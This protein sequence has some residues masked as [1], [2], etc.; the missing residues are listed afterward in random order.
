M[1]VVSCLQI[2]VKEFNF[3]QGGSLSIDKIREFDKKLMDREGKMKRKKTIPVK[4]RRKGE[5][6]ENVLKCGKRSQKIGKENKRRK[7]VGGNIAT[8]EKM[9]LLIMIDTDTQNSTTTPWAGHKYDVGLNQ[10]LQPCGD[11]T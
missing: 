6:T 11:H 8:K 4:D 2:W 1:K 9:L 7:K 5:N 10:K 3:P